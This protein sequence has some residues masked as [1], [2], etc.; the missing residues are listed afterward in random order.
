LKG[1]TCRNQSNVHR[2]YHVISGQAVLYHSDEY[3]GCCPHHGKRVLE[4][5]ECH[6]A[7]AA[8]DQDWHLYLV[9]SW[10][11]PT[12]AI[13]DFFL[14][15][16]N[17]TS[18]DLARNTALEGWSYVGSA[19]AST[20]RM[21]L[22]EMLRHTLELND[23]Y[24]YRYHHVHIDIMMAEAYD[25]ETPRSRKMNNE[26][27]RVDRITDPHHLGLHQHHETQQEWSESATD[28]TASTTDRDGSPSVGK[29]NDHR[30]H[31]R[32]YP[33]VNKQT[34][35]PPIPHVISND[36]SLFSLSGASTVAMTSYRDSPSWTA[37]AEAVAG[38][39]TGTSQLPLMPHQSHYQHQ[40]HH[41][42]H[43][44][45][46]YHPW[47]GNRTNDGPT[48]TS[49]SYFGPD[50]RP[51]SEHHSAEMQWLP[52]NAPHHHHH[53]HH[54][55]PSLGGFNAVLSAPPHHP[56]LWGEQQRQVTGVTPA[57]TVPNQLGTHTLG[58]HHYSHPPLPP[59]PHHQYQHHINGFP[60]MHDM[61]QY[62]PYQEPLMVPPVCGA[63]DYRSFS[64]HR[65]SQYQPLMSSLLPLAGGHPPPPPP[66][67]KYD[68]SRQQQCRH[69]TTH[70]STAV[71]REILS[72]PVVGGG[73]CSAI[74]A[75]SLLSGSVVSST[76]NT[77]ETVDGPK[78]ACPKG[79]TTSSSKTSPKLLTTVDHHGE[80]IGTGGGVESTSS[81]TST[82][83]AA[84]TTS[85][86]TPCSS[87]TNPMTVATSPNWTNGRGTGVLSPRRSE[88]HHLSD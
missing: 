76:S 20:I 47:G 39:W 22:D 28:E 46:T 37:T 85:V 80:G 61:E 83:T 13:H 23:H 12:H 34:T 5:Q 84:N 74:S 62:S 24:G 65:H 33:F 69:R 7:D 16:H 29:V 88:A 30:S 68:N 45:H 58:S 60:D 10:L 59:Q 41:H 56:H 17:Q 73:A 48:M 1:K 63:G 52:G 66:H 18:I 55:A 82:A 75:S 57:G 70:S 49:G 2:P 67:P 72:P 42:K 19:R 27:G 87:S 3:W 15:P 64:T 21:E 54:D 8:P 11:S 32:N 79:N 44:G 50:G 9:G 40:H 36:S 25:R 86:P 6:F 38:Y 26:K 77:I 14:L 81:S 78:T 53:H 35:A 4:L 43:L 71:P 51:I 31:H